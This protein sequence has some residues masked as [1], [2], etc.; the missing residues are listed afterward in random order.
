[1][2]RPRLSTAVTWSRF[3]KAVHALLLEVLRRL[4]AY[5]HLSAAEE[6]I[7]LEVYW[8][9][10]RVHQEQLNSKHGSL[11]FL[12]DPDTTNKP[13]PDDSA[14]SSRMKK[15]PDF[16]CVLKDSQAPDFR[17]SQIAYYTEC[18]RLGK[19]EKELVFNDLYS[20]KGIARFMT[21]EHQYGK[22]C[23]SASMIGY[24][25]DMDPDDILEEVNEFAGGR[26]VPSL[27]RAAA[28]W[29]A[30]DVTRISQP[31]LTRAFEA[32]T[33]TLTHFWIDLRHCTFDIPSDQPPQA[34]AM[35]TSAGEKGRKKKAT[36]K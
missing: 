24:M 34:A 15:R 10:L 16:A 5:G 3:E 17:K 4:A 13:L 26:S 29:A 23:A 18:K 11:P 7:N 32:T 20:E 22:G 19:P 9:A 30:K 1:M 25:Q 8:L 12:I 2:A 31:P 6:P 14:R 35:T 27:T 33:I 28:A 21:V 36:K